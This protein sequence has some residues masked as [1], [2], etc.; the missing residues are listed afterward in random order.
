MRGRRQNERVHAIAAGSESTQIVK[1]KAEDNNI[2]NRND[3]G[4]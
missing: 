4:E 3:P 2:W 1:G